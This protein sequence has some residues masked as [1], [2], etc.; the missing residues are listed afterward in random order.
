MKKRNTLVL[1]LI[2]FGYSTLAAAEEDKNSA[3]QEKKINYN[4][5]L[6]VAN[7]YFWRG[8]D[9]YSPS[10]S[11]PQ[12]NFNLVP[13]LFPSLTMDFS[14]GFSFNVWS[15]LALASRNSASGD[16][17]SLDE[18]DLTLAYEIEDISGTFSTLLAVYTYPTSKG[19]A[20]PELVTSYTAPWDLLNP[21]LTYAISFGPE[22]TQY[23]Y[24]SFSL[25]HEFETGILNIAPDLA[26]GYWINTKGS[27]LDL[28]IPFTFA[29]TES[30]EMHTGVLGS[31]R[32]SGFDGAP[33]IVVANLGTSFSF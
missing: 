32:F 12:K 5:A 20:Y 6:D 24:S 2:L 4:I 10:L 9:Y 33:F 14:N 22:S 7:V 3:E 15:A 31:Y 17:Q 13:G 21:S 28:N 18:V 19:A 16:L 30:F 11:D 23:Q 8:Y 26:F 1:C 25:S 29:F 27:H